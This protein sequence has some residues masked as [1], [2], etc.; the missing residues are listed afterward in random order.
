MY[1]W[2]LRR[3]T[4]Y[5]EA[6]IRRM[7]CARCGK[8]ARYQWNICA[9][10]NYYRPLCEVCDVQLNALV[11]AWVGH[12]DGHALLR[13]YALEKGISVHKLKEIVG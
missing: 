7:R 1:N 4:P 9:D 11:L 12:P 10:N 5:T 6:G 2:K 3:R 13:Q 8:P